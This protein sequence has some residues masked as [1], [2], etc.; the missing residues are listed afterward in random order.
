MEVFLIELL[1]RKYAFLNIH[2]LQ[3]STTPLIM[4][5]IRNSEKKTSR[6]LLTW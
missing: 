2:S 4:I 6:N 1:V 5:D 3:Y